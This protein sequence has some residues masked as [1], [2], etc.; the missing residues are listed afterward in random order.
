MEDG[1]S[2]RGRP[3]LDVFTGVHSQ[4]CLVSA[5]GW[6]CSREDVGILNKATRSS[7][8]RLNVNVLLP[9]FL[10]MR[11]VRTASVEVLLKWW[12]LPMFVFFNLLFGWVLGRLLLF[13]VHVPKPQQGVVLAV[14][15]IGNCGILPLALVSAAC[16]PAVREKFG[17][18]EEEECIVEA[19]G[20]VV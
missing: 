19:E 11:M 18:F 20:M 17:D 2:A 16:A 15:A 5:I 7:L 9:S 10:F 6:V 8:S 14:T 1:S 3:T 13:G 4:V 12:C